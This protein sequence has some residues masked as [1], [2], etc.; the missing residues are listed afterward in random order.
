MS[1]ACVSSIIATNTYRKL[2]TVFSFLQLTF[3]IIK[4]ACDNLMTLY[5]LILKQL[6]CKG[7]AIFQ[8]NH[9][10]IKQKAKRFP[11]SYSFH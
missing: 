1:L 11:P 10:K 6:V 2:N 5:Y 3:Q 9:L 7:G 4:T 8:L